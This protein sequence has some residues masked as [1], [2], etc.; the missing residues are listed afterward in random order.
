MIMNREAPY[1]DMSD[2]ELEDA[3]RA[4]PRRQPSQAVRHRIV[5]QGR[6]RHARPASFLRPALGLAALVVLIFAD[7]LVVRLQ[8]VSL[9]SK[10]GPPTAM[11]VAAQAPDRTEQLAW[12]QEMGAPDLGPHIAQM[13]AERPPHSPTYAALLAD[14]VRS[15]NGG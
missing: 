3:V 7:L 6:H 9:A 2:E 12:L 11:L 1:R 13:V 15:G 10:A 5:S 4:L 8:N 14:L